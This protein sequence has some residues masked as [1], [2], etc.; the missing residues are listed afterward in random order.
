MRSE[1]IRCL[2]SLSCGGWS[3]WPPGPGSQL[4]L[5]EASGARQAPHWVMPAPSSSRLRCPVWRRQWLLSG[6]PPGPLRRPRLPLPCWRQMQKSLGQTS[7]WTASWR[8]MQASPEKKIN[9]LRI[10]YVIHIL[11]CVQS[12]K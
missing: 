4:R 1:Y 6:R 8:T 10:C 9:I 11:G 5:D 7:Y 3:S 2:L 12:G